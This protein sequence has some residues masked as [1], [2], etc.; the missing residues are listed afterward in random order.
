MTPWF[1]YILR[2]S[3]NSLYTGVTLNIERRLYEHNQGKSKGAKYTRTRRPVMLAYCEN[4]T[5]K[6]AAYQREYQL[7]HL[8][9]ADKE[10]L[11]AQTK[12]T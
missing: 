10:R 11:I 5:D 7:K 6:S 4:F 3:D 9:K 8:S 1:L 12:P 2:C